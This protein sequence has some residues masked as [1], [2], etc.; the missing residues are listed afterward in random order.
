MKRFMIVLMSV[1]LALLPAHVAFSKGTVGVT[2][3]YDLKS[4]SVDYYA[5]ISDTHYKILANSKENG[6]RLGIPFTFDLS[7]SFSISG[8]VNL[9]FFSGQNNQTYIE[10]Y[11]PND[12]INPPPSD[13]EY[14]Q[15][16][17]AVFGRYEI[18]KS[19]YSNIGLQ[20]GLMN[21]TAFFT[22]DTNSDI[23]NIFLFSLGAYA[24]LWITNK[25]VASVDFRLPI[26][27][28]LNYGSF[29]DESD[30]FFKGF[31]CDLSFDVLYVISP[32]V[33][34]GI[35]FNFNTA[36]I[37]GAIHNY[38]K[39]HSNTSNLYAFSVGAKFKYYF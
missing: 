9:S 20:A 19:A 29:F 11:P 16:D 38:Y 25:I 13:I 4:Y 33:D 39:K 28:I 1:L 7:S 35:V 23:Y 21:S 3:S 30:G 22:L 36:T 37:D 32:S 8:N 10:F 6:I 5:L 24:S 26:G 31:L 27:Y 2:L 17:V 14:L 12:I 18:S 15:L 34:V